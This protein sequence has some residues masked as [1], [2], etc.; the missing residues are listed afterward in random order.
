M[1]DLLNISKRMKEDWNSRTSLDYHF[2]MAENIETD[3]EMW[4]SGKADIN[5]L[6]ENLHPDK[7]KNWSVL[8][9]GSGTGRVLRAASYIFE[10]VTGVDVSDTAILKGKELLSDRANITLSPVNGLDLGDF[11]DETFDMAFSISCLSHIPLSALSRILFE[12][13]RVIKENGYLIVQFYT[14]TTT[15]L[16]AEDTIQPRA[17]SK[18]ALLSA[19]AELGFI[20]YHTREYKPS[21]DP[22]DHKKKLI[23]YIFTLKKSASDKPLSI[24]KESQKNHEMVLEEIINPIGENPASSN[25]KGSFFEYQLAATLLERKAKKGEIEQM[26]RIIEFA[27]KRYKE[28]DHGT[29]DLLDKLKQMSEA[30]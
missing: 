23:P 11:K 16:I 14:G 19:F 20:P 21:F 3:E 29:K 18:E 9:Y 17:Y 24:K 15:D 8:E 28:P 5:L 2:W 13:T 22:V 10:K 7:I 30:N 27:L 4:E 26:I 6:I 25:W 1:S 12:L